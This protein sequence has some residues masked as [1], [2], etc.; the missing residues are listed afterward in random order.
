[1]KPRE[2][3]ISAGLFAAGGVAVAVGSW[4]GLA[5]AKVADYPGPPPGLIRCTNLGSHAGD[6]V[7][8][9]PKAKNY[10]TPEQPI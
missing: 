8:C 10:I 2:R 5:P 3:I 4:L 9:R 1:M 6:T 7:R